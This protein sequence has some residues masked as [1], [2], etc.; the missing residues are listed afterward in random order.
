MVTLLIEMLTLVR[1]SGISEAEA[2]NTRDTQT[3]TSLRVGPELNFIFIFIIEL[4]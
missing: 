2:D 1:W 3:I 4:T